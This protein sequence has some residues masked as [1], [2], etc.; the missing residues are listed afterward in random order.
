MAITATVSGGT[1]TTSI[2]RS[3]GKSQVISVAIPG[4]KG[5][6]GTVVAGQNL[7]LT[8]LAD[9]NTIALADGSMLMYSESTSKWV[10]KNELEPDSGDL[11]LSG[12]NF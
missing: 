12:G 3:D 5:D 1:T 8:D 9:I 10:A 6:S 2:V 11:V 7:N 4:P